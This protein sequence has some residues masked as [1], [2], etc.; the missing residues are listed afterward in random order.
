MGRSFL[1]QCGFSDQ[2]KR[3]GELCVDGDVLLQLDDVI[4]ERDLDMSNKITRIRYTHN[5]RCT[6]NCVF[7]VCFKSKCVLE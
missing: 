3:F 7:F 5:S 1:F 2:A 6:V 4:L